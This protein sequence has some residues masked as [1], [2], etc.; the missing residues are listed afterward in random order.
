MTLIQYFNENRGK[1]L[2]VGGHRGHASQVRENTIAN[3]EQL[4]PVT[5]IRYI[6]IDVQL[7]LDGAAVI[8]H[9]AELSRR[10]GLSGMIRDYTLEQLRGCFEINTMEE[11][12]AWCREKG[13]GI[14][15][16]IK[17]VPFSMWED[18]RLLAEALVNVIRE[19]DFYQM[20]FV[21]GKDHE[22]LSWIREMD[23]R[24]PIGL[25]AP[26]VPKDPVALMEEMGAFLYLNFVDQLSRE[27]VDKLH[28]A[29]YLVDGSVVN[30]RE[31]LEKALALGVDLVESDEPE[32]LLEMLREYG[33]G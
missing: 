21:F 17:L 20:C 8:Y 4:L 10:T 7:T 19:Y 32:K 15:F 29:G 33:E 22:M 25:I 24:I 27:L 3:F 6:E 2:M 23:A 1:R 5:E 9:D 14:A 12:A 31:E 11:A 28:N 18:R 26:F 13:L 16:E 30:T